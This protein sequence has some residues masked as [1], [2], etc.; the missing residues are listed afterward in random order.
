MYA[1]AVPQNTDIFIYVRLISEHKE[2][3]PHALPDQSA[4][5]AARMKSGNLSTNNIDNTKTLLLDR[6]YLNCKHFINI[7]LE[8]CHMPVDS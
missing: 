2:D 3:I 1:T 5:L 7:A 6:V 4:L 8:R